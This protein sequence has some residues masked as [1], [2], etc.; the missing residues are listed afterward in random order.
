MKVLVKKN[1]LII[2]Y[3]KIKNG[4]MMDY[5]NTVYGSDHCNY[6]AIFSSEG[7]ARPLQSRMV[8]VDKYPKKT[9][10]S[11][12]KVVTRERLLCYSPID[13][14]D[15]IVEVDIRFNNKS[16]VIPSNSYDSDSER[17]KDERIN[18]KIDINQWDGLILTTICSSPL[19]VYNQPDKGY[20]E[21]IFPLEFEE[22]YE[23]MAKQA[24]NLN[25]SLL[26]D[27]NSEI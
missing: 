1:N 18:I 11:D 7:E 8:K 13:R 2:K 3:N 26:R 9:K 23:K 21:V 10:H 12:D 5:T 16:A 25:I 6:I 15:F 20:L 27:Y 17:T 14:D 19:W 24:V 22:K 4:T